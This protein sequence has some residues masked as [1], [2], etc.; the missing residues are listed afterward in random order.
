[1]QTVAI[2]IVNNFEY[3]KACNYL[4]DIVHFNNLFLSYNC[5]SLTIVIVLKRIKI[6]S[7]IHSFIHT[8]GLKKEDKVKRLLNYLLMSTPSLRWTHYI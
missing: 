4:D 6:H 7:F 8:Y 2:E 5:F 3:T 1:M